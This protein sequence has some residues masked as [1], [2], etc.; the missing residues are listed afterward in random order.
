MLAMD[1]VYSPSPV[2]TEVTRIRGLLQRG[3]HVEAQAVAEALA[4]RVPENRDVLYLIAVSLRYQH[5]ISEALATLERLERFHPK[6]S[7]LYQE[8]GHCH[9]VL[10]DAPR[11]IEAY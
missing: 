1:S 2:E 3:R 10:E 11:A 9:V 5:K 6:F 7:R 4:V 8:R